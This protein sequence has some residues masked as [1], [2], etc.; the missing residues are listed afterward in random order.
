M[1]KRLPGVL[2]WVVKG[3][4]SGMDELKLGRR[5]WRNLLFR[6]TITQSCQIKILKNTKS[7]LDP[8]KNVTSWMRKMKISENRCTRKIRKKS[9]GGG[10][11]IPATAQQLQDG[12][13]A[14]VQ[15]QVCSS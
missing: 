11:G 14:Q 5:F 3:P 7:E 10:P 2:P 8:S 4:S 12:I 6:R 15:A 9:D 13:A 1:K